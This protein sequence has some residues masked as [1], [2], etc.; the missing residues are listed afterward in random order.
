MLARR[1]LSLIRGPTFVS[2]PRYNSSS[3]TIHP[4]GA[5][6]FF[7]ER[8]GLDYVPNKSLLNNYCAALV[9]AAAC[10]GMDPREEAYVLGLGL[11]QGLEEAEIRENLDQEWTNAKIEATL[12]C[13][14]GECPREWKGFLIYDCV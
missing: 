8:Y 4:L 3:S 13:F 1:A 10:D 14:A 9:A 5:L 2:R 12:Q 7:K 6:F 11:C